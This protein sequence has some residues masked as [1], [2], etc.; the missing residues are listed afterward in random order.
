MIK[1]FIVFISILAVAFYFFR[2]QPAPDSQ[3]AAHAAVNFKTLASL[4]GSIHESSGIELMPQQGMYITH[5]DAGNNAQLYV[6]D[7]KGK[8]INT[9]TLKLP[10][11]DWEDLA[12]DDKGNLY[13]SDTGNNNNKRRELAI[14]KVPF[15]NLQQPEAIRFRYADQPENSSKKDR[16]S[17]DSEALFWSEGNLYLVTKDRN[18]SNVAEVYQ[19]PDQPGNYTAKQ[20]G[21]LE[22]KEP[23]TGASISPDGHTVAL[24]SEGKIHLFRQVA[25]PQTFFKKK[26]EEIKLPGAGQTEGI[27]FED[28]DN[29]IITSE[30]GNLYRYTL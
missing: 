28:N 4:P 20:I 10:N 27:T 16:K 18:G 3:A 15:D 24:L 1:V 11:V 13:I 21:S 30:G 19:L 14:Y 29:L 12:R 6:I 23:V 8:L 2:D 5:N 17:F 7:Q 22:M 9:H 25:S 26:P